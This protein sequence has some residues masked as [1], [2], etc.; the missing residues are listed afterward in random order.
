MNRYYFTFGSNHFTKEGI[1]MRNCYV[2]VNSTD[3]VSAEVRFKE[4]V[5]NNM[6]SENAWSWVYTEEE[7]N[8]SRK[9]HPGGIYTILNV[10]GDDFVNV[11]DKCLNNLDDLLKLT[12]KMTIEE[13]FKIDVNLGK[14]NKK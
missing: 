14:Q 5:K 11:L 13:A 4:W 7:F 2:Q 8:E 6:A 10:D 1:S 9:Y 12:K 3:I